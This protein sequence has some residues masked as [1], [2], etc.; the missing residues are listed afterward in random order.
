MPVCA[1][2]SFAGMSNCIYMEGRCIKYGQQSSFSLWY[3]FLEDACVCVFRK[4]L[5][6]RYTD[7]TAK[8]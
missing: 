5:K 8:K 4:H 7:I 6:L 3:L 2:L 1:R